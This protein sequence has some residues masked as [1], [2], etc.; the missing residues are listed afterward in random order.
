MDP[1]AR[2]VV[3]TSAIWNERKT[4]FKS[5]K[6]K[7][8]GRGRKKA[9]AKRVRKS[10]HDEVLFLALGDNQAAFARLPQLKLS[11]SFPSNLQGGSFKLARP[12]DS[13]HETKLCQIVFLKVFER[14]KQLHSGCKS[15]VQTIE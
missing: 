2:M 13:L 10:Y 5:S 7:I 15:F 14:L 11:S 4:W 12:I 1:Q 6:S 8:H 9:V 3:E